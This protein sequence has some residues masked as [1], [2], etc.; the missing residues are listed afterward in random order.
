MVVFSI[1]KFLPNFFQMSSQ[2]S[3]VT[4]LRDLTLISI[5]AGSYHSAAVDDEGRLWTWGW[6][7]HGQV[8]ML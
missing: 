8:S 7:V 2:P 1:F 4:E 5:A 3:M 6:G